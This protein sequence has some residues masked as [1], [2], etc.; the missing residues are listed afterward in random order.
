MWT[1]YMQTY[2]DRQIPSIRLHLL[3]HK[4]SNMYCTQCTVEGIVKKNISNTVYAVNRHQIEKET[5]LLT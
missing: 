3:Y 1:G 4:Y 5:V 2:L